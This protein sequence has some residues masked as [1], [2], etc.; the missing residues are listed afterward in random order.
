MEMLMK[1]SRYRRAAMITASLALSLA[2]LLLTA[3]GGAALAAVPKNVELPVISP[4]A[5]EIGKAAT[6]STGAWNSEAPVHW[7]EGES[8]IL[9]SGEKVAVKAVSGR[10]SYSATISGLSGSINC[11][12]EVASTTLENPATGAAGVGNANLTYQG[13]ETEGSWRKCAGSFAAETIPVKF[14]LSTTEGTEKIAI[15]P[16]GSN[17]GKFSLVGASCPEALEGTIGVFGTINGRYSNL[18][19]SI[20][21]NSSTGSTLRLRNEI[22]GPKATAAGGVTLTSSKGAAITAHGLTYTYAWSRCEGSCTAIPGAT[23]SNYTPERADLGKSLK[24][25][26]TATDTNGSA[27]ATS[28]ASAAVV[29]TPAWY[30]SPTSNVWEKIGSK[31]FTSTNSF[32]KGAKVPLKVNLNYEK[33]AVLEIACGTS[34]GAG[35]LTS[36]LAKASIEGYK[37]K[38]SECVLENHTPCHLESASLSFSSMGASS[39][40]TAA[41]FSPTLT[42]Y[43]TVPSAYLLEIKV[44]GCLALEGDYELGG[45]VPATVPNEPSAGGG[46]LRTSGPEVEQSKLLVAYRSHQFIGYA[47][48]EGAAR[49]LSEGSKPVKL[50]VSP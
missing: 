40:A 11:G 33:Q 42:L 16:T 48:I 2:A 47:G 29:G 1:R 35:T 10:F 15:Q 36:G 41:S 4:T 21:F 32:S 18:T 9:K 39:A 50:D 14:N 20:N 28:L 24:V 49:L 27:A 31:S 13:C 25:T 26:V 22:T 34:E 30:E 19:S 12:T 3:A 38:L 5:V 23:A 37:L 8:S 46:V 43:P 44:V 45:S 7:F 17:L 6:A